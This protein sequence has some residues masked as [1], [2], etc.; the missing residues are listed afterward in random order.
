[1]NDLERAIWEG[2]T[3][4]LHELAPCRCCCAEHYYPNCPAVAWSG[5]RGAQDHDDIEAWQKFYEETRGMPREVFFG[6]DQ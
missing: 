5:C 2:D 1:M 4:R 6:L 3:D